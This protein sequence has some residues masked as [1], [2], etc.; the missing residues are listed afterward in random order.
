MEKEDGMV[1]TLHCVAYAAQLRLILFSFLP[2]ACFILAFPEF[3][4]LKVAQRKASAAFFVPGVRAVASFFW[5]SVFGFLDRYSNNRFVPVVTVNEKS[6][7]GLC[8]ARKVV[9]SR[10]SGVVDW[11]F[12]RRKL[13]RRA[14]A[15]VVF[16]GAP[17]EHGAPHSSL[18]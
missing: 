9:V 1:A 16:E 11:S 5:R 15:V 12:W 8:D 6:Q 14:A 3:P 13:S 4:R 17:R 10:G 18:T 7:Q 2:L